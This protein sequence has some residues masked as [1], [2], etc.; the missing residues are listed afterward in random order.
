MLAIDV[1]TIK[2]VSKPSGGGGDCCALQHGSLTAGDQ[3]HNR[4]GTIL[5]WLI[6]GLAR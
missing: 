4:I 6:C 3:H 1:S 5:S 2:P